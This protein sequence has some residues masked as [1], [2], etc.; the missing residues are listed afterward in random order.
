M[1][2]PGESQGW[3]SL[4]GFHL[5]GRTES[6]HNWS[7]LAAAAT[8]LPPFYCFGG[9][10]GGR[11]HKTKYFQSSL[12]YHRGIFFI[13]FK[14]IYTKAKLAHNTCPPLFFSC[15]LNFNNI[16]YNNSIPILVLL[17][18]FLVP[19]L[20]FPDYASLPSTLLPNITLLK[21]GFLK[22][23]MTSGIKA[24]KTGSTKSALN[25]KAIW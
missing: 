19:L 6:G 20:L 14:I 2:F 13:I 9:Q 8:L 5:W 22:N 18:A 12:L 23:H 11:E 25:P 16:L 17:L 3:G 21:Q 4:V 15:F 1:S 7:D 24:F 10:E